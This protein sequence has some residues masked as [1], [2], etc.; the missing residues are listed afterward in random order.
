M[1][2]SP[3]WGFIRFMTIIQSPKKITAGRIH[4]S[5]VA[6]H[7]FVTCPVKRTWAASS[8]GTSPG[9]ST[10]VVTKLGALLPDRLISSIF[11]FARMPS[12]PLGASVPSIV[13]LYSASSLTLP[14]LRRALNSLYDMFSGWGASRIAWIPK[15]TSIASAAYHTENVRCFGSIVALWTRYGS[16]HPVDG[17]EIRSGMGQKLSVGWM[18]DRLDAHDPCLEGVI[19]RVPVAEKLELGGRGPHEEN[20]V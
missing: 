16:A 13:S 7:V 10:R 18:V 11:S 12:R 9:S 17:L 8:S 5:N 14:A 19:V 20:L 2:I 6:S 4:D 15:N 3:L 1:D